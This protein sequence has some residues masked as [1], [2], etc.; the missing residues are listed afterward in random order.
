MY[1]EYDVVVTQIYWFHE[2]IYRN[3]I[4]SQKHVFVLVL[5]WE[6]SKAAQWID[7]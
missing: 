2:K 1:R 5:V 3:S 6:S 4:Q 7:G